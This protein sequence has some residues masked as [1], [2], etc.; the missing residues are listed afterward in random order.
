METQRFANIVPN[1]V[2]HLCHRDFTVN[3]FTI[4]ADTLIQPVFAEIL[5]GDYWKDGMTFRPERFLDDKGDVR[6]DEH[7][8]PFSIGKRQCLG[9]T[10]AKAEMFLFFTSLIHQFK[11]LPE[12]ET[13]LPSEEYTPGVT[14]LPVPFKARLVSR[15]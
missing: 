7:F 1:G 5:K 8:I 13:K 15:F 9:E 3:G 4:P 11:F 6:R 14:I 12:D 10:L 2:Q